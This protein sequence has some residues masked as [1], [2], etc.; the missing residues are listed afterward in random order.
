MPDESFC[1]LAGNRVVLRRFG[2]EDLAE[3]V[4][5]R[6]SGQVARFQSWDAP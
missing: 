6:C 1:E 5:Y 4:V 3:F 2:L